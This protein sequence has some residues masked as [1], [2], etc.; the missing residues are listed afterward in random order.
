MGLKS[1]S[2]IVFDKETCFDSGDVAN[3]FV[4]F[5]WEQGKRSWNFL[6]FSGRCQAGALAGIGS[7]VVFCLKSFLR[8][9]N[10]ENIRQA[11]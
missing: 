6:I 5:V 10:L 1:R 2:L 3:W 9:A 7:P 4:V 11:L 8:C